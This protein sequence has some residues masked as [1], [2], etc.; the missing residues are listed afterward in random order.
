MANNR[1]E[2]ILDFL[3][4]VQADAGEL[5]KVSKLIESS[6]S[7]NIKFG[8]GSFL[9][10]AANM[11]K[12]LDGV[13]KD[14]Q[15]I[16]KIAD[17]IDLNL[18]SKEAQDELQK[19]TNLADELEKGLNGIKI[20]DKEFEKLG[21]DL[22]Q[23]SKE[24]DGMG[25]SSSFTDR[26]AKFGMVAMGVDQ[27]TNSLQIVT[28][29]AIEFEQTLAEVSQITGFTGDNLNLLGDKARGL[30]KEFGGTAT[31]QLNSFK[32]ILSKFGPDM[33][34][35]AD[36]LEL[37]SKNVNI[38]AKAS[39]MDAAQSMDS[40][41]NAM[42][43][44]GLV[45]EDPLE[46]AKNSTIAINA[47]AASAQVGA[48]EIPQVA[49]ALLQAGVAAKGANMDIIATNAALQVLAV[50]GKTG[51]EAGTALRN[52]LGL[53][54]NASGPAEAEM[55][56]L[57]TSSKE[58]GQLLTTKGLD[59][60]MQKV[61]EGMNGLGSDAEKN[62][63][64]MTIFGTENAAAAGILMQNLDKYKEF[65]N[66][67]KEGTEGVG[68]A[69]Q[70][71]KIGMDTTQG[72][73][74]RFKAGL[75]DIFI[76]LGS[77]K[78][79]GAFTGIAQQT[80]P[81]V[82]TFTGL[83]AI[84]PEKTMERIGSSVKSFGKGIFTLVPGI[85]KA[86]IAQ[87]G[88]NKAILTNPYIIAAAAVAGL[89]VGLHYLAEALHETAAEKLDDIK[90]DQA[91][92]KSKVEANRQQQNVVKG[93]IDL[94][95]SFKEAGSSAMND[96]KL[97]EDLS[98]AYPGVIS[99]SKSYEEN[100]KALTTASKGQNGEL[101]KLKSEMANLAKESQ[102]LAKQELK[103]NIAVKK[104]ELED[105]LTDA[106]DGF[107]NDMFKNMGGVGNIVGVFDEAFDSI[108]GTS[109]TRKAVEGMTKGMV[110]AISSA[111]NDAELTKA[112]ADLSK[113]IYNN[114][115]LSKQEKQSAIAKIREITEAKR[116]ALVAE[117]NQMGSFISN[118]SNNGFKESEIIEQITINFGK[119]KSEAKKL[120]E[121][122]QKLTKEAKDTKDQVQGIGEAF[123]TALN[124]SQSTYQKNFN[125]SLGYIMELK[126][127]QRKGDKEGIKAAQDKL[128]QSRQAAKEADKQVDQLKAIQEAE[129]SRYENKQA[130][131]KAEKSLY[132]TAE[133][134]ANEKIKDYE[135]ELKNYELSQKAAILEQGRERTAYDD[136]MLS[137]KKLELAKSTSQEWIKQLEA[138]KLIT[139]DEQG[140]WIVAP[141]VKQEDAEKIKEK[142]QSTALN[143]RDAELD[144]SGLKVK[145]D[146]DEKALNDKL[147]D[148][149]RQNIESTI[150]L[151]LTFK[152]NEIG[153]YT[154]KIKAINGAALAEILSNNE[155][156]KDIQEQYDKESD[157]TK[158]L[159]YKAE[160]I[161]LRNQNLS[162]KELIDKGEQSIEGINNKLTDKRLAQIE[163]AYNEQNK[164]IE[165][166]YAERQA[167]LQTFNELFASNYAEAISKA[168]E[169]EISELEKSNEERITSLENLAEL[170]LISKEKLEERK[171][172]IEE[173][174]QKKRDKIEE[175]TRLEKLRMD[176]FLA[177]QSIE[178]ERQKTLETAKLQEKG[179]KEQISELEKKKSLQ[180]SAFSVADQK[181]LDDLNKQFDD[182]GQ[183]IKENASK[184]EI[185]YEMAGKGV[186]EAMT[187]LIAGD[188]EAAADALRA[189]FSSIFGVMAKALS[190]YISGAILDTVITWLGYDPSSK[191]LP[192][193]IKL[194]LIPVTTALV[195]GAVN[196]I[197]DPILNGLMSFATGSGPLTSPQLAWV[198]DA[199][200]AERVLRDD[201][202]MVL[203][204]KTVQEFANTVLPSLKSY[205]AGNTSEMLTADSIYEQAMIKIDQKDVLTNKTFKA[206]INDIK[207]EAIWDKN[208]TAE[209]TRTVNLNVTPELTATVKEAV[210]TAVATAV[211]AIRQESSA[212]TVQTNVN[213]D[214]TAVVS[215]INQVAD[216]LRAL[217]I[218]TSISGSQIKQA[219]RVEQAKNESKVY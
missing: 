33:A 62:A 24:L 76:S 2:M 161:A 180:G 146:I 205:M 54:Q 12:A 69:F 74:D 200:V 95:K 218:E 67:I 201:Q 122:Q 127:A 29:P 68:S 156:V 113:K 59:A 47:L 120:Y 134:L 32:G 15:D 84:M 121:E 17:R 9:K 81:L 133:K 172:K 155:K 137:Q 50:G 116:Q 118:L 37:M 194:G 166:K 39:G 25:K 26:F 112:A 130:G 154:A 61:K 91:L 89:V 153:E 184:L 72:T 96:K 77:N 190:T 158:K 132:E 51:A 53:L 115:D 41:T 164:I 42:L 56:K 110:G 106:L 3:V 71:A 75:E 174:A 170:E 150:E 49:D 44:M 163:E 126:E 160:I 48:A 7:P 103:L 168:K 219:L 188:P 64:L 183:I 45:S 86:T 142:L 181:T 203:M 52:V 192:L 27:L 189:T 20:D 16:E 111:K 149:E 60:A 23:A 144:L 13:T 141:K 143:L 38:L 207:P 179:L 46:T 80:A 99:A 182:V 212:T 83:S 128:K 70:Q 19:M 5:K 14:L 100:L 140:Q 173:E 213:S 57:G 210:Q 123:S 215:A 176:K 169:D 109:L 209:I 93:Q 186:S 105:Q 175:K 87:K 138:Q 216:L 145:I 195:S 196:A 148:I 35:N 43:Q 98:S 171:T 157:E 147:L 167:M 1:L 36:A 21:K 94:V 18:N 92:I 102:S 177:G 135:Y 159:A 4:K 204:R 185:G 214:N 73:L 202:L 78:I 40:L 125:E 28:Q 191:L 151:D 152:G 55:K 199:P 131:A 136:V 6:V 65:T 104:E 193:P 88:L 66:G 58:L 187:A 114:P 82:T 85:D 31:S 8:S 178:M 30:A 11:E 197:A 22:D 101:K 79:V 198:G 139:K 211:G 124:A 10:D 165:S 208:I 90:A 206:I 119:S 117:T 108:F 107:G 129:T 97:I 217:N 63:A 34:Q 162:K